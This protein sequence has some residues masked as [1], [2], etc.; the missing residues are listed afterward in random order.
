M[1]TPP[2]FRCLR[3]LSLLL[4]YFGC[5]HQPKPA[6]GEHP[7]SSEAE[8]S[9]LRL[10]AWAVQGSPYC[11]FVQATHVEPWRAGPDE[12]T[13]RVHARVLETVRGPS[14]QEIV[15]TITTEPG[16]TVTP[17][18]DP[19]LVALCRDAEGLYWPG[20]G[21]TFPSDGGTRDAA[22]RASASA[23]ADQTVFANCE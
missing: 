15:Y 12:E 5:A 19:V 23:P 20:V 22:R 2:P 16:D 4:L 8:S 21:S 9:M 6:A 1:M 17:S 7:S 18:E 13:Y 3:G 10:V 14:V 11:A